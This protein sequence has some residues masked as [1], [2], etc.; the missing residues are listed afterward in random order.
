M[1]F[2]ENAEVLVEPNL[3]AL[4]TRISSCL[5]SNGIELNDVEGLNDILQ[6]PSIFSEAKQPLSN[7]YLQLKYFLER[8]D[9]V[10]STQ[11]MQPCKNADCNFYGELWDYNKIVIKCL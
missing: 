7:Q 1:Q 9:L 4:K 5:V 3:E 2:L 6:E 10:V 11:N 8:L